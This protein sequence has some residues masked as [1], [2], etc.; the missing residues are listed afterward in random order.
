MKAAALV[1]SFLRCRHFIIQ[2]FQLSTS[3]WLTAD[4]WWIHTATFSYCLVS[5]CCLSHGGFQLCRCC[6]CALRRSQGM[7]NQSRP[8]VGSEEWVDQSVP[9]LQGHLRPPAAARG[10]LGFET[11]THTHTHNRLIQHWCMQMPRHVVKILCP[12]QSQGCLKIWAE[13]YLMCLFIAHI[14]LC[15]YLVCMGCDFSEVGGGSF[16]HLCLT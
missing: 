16:A 9:T 11:R 4:S 8:A 13:L 15:A 5:F 2:F 7:T 3:S 14:T 1:W 12:H 6:C 10:N